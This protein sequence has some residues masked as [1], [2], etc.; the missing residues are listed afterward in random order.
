MVSSLSAWLLRAGPWATFLAMPPFNATSPWTES[1][2]GSTLT[3]SR[4]CNML[5]TSTYPSSGVRQRIELV[6]PDDAAR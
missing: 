1:G 6:G 2:G 4:H 3:N 5:P